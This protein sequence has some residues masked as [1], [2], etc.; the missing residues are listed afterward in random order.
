MLVTR[1]CGLV[2]VLG[3]GEIRG[4]NLG[5]KGGMATTSRYVFYWYLSICISGG[6]DI[7]VSGQRS[8]AIQNLVSEII[9]SRGVGN[10]RPI[11]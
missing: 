1:P 3:L 8:D 7:H 9:P 11:N 6:F 4:K 2:T 5:W 10:D